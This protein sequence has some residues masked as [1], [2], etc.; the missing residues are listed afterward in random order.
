M[1]DFLEILALQRAISLSAQ[2][3][4]C[5]RLLVVPS[6]AESAGETSRIVFVIFTSAFLGN[7]RLFNK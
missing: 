4:I 5:L 6:T 1:A 2:Q 7:E 3:T